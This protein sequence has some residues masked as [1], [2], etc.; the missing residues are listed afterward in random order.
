MTDKAQDPAPAP[1]PTL[2]EEVIA[3]IVAEVE[4]SAT[5]TG[6]AMLQAGLSSWM[7][8]IDIARPDG[9]PH[10][11]V[12]RRGRQAD[13]ERRPMTLQTEFELITYLEA[14]NI[15]VARPRLFDRSGDIIP[16]AYIV[17]DFVAGATRFAAN[18]PAATA[19]RMA[20]MLAAIHALDPTDV[21]LP[22]LPSHAARMEHWI[23]N[24]LTRREPDPSLREDLIRFHLDQHWPPT[25]SEVCLLHADFFPGNIVW[26]NDDIAAVI[27]WESSAIGDPMADL[28]TTR[29]DL[30]WAYGAEA[31]EA[32]TDRYLTIT[33]RSPA[34][35]P[36]WELVVSLRPAGAISLWAN[37][38]KAHGRPDITATSMRT[39][40]HAFVDNAIDR[41]PKSDTLQ[42]R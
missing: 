11:L 32:F 19:Y 13:H 8:T 39:E 4:P 7:T 31:A 20:E 17:L 29:L 16:Q 9:A 22:S 28:A 40:Q 10:R 37:D 27:D 38:M 2:T 21:L 35:L 33:G 30:R 25:D 26:S 6:T 12:V 41:L 42:V 24:D 1:L 23:I 5:V 14:H 15:T 36:I 34:T 3:A 18:Q